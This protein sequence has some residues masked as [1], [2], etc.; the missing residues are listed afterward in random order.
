MICENCGQ[1]FKPRQK[2]QFLCSSEACK[3][4][5]NRIYMR[6]K[7]NK[8]PL[9]DMKNCIICG[10]AF[11]PRRNDQVLCSD[12]CRKKRAKENQRLRKLREKDKNN[13]SFPCPF[14]RPDFIRAW[15]EGC[16][17]GGCCRRPNRHLG[18]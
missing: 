15:I 17:P 6:K 11:S 2:N 9:P 5:Y 3:K 1:E 10:G 14:S 13:F 8:T 4:A 12:V 16:G 7:Y 18:F